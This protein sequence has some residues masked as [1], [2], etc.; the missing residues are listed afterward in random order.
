MAISHRIVVMNKGKFEQVGTPVEVYDNPVSKYVASFIGEMNFL[1]EGDKVA[2]VRPEDVK[3][4]RGQKEG[5]VSGSIRTIMILGHYAEVNVQCGAQV[6]KSFIPR[7]DLV[8]L[9]VGNEVY[10]EFGKSN[11]FRAGQ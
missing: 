11:N 5:A 9:D 1:E 3:I 8:D 7:A 4:Y 2:A 6:I 10:L